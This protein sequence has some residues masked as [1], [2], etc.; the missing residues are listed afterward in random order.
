[1]KDKNWW[2]CVLG[3]IPVNNKGLIAHGYTFQE[4]ASQ[5][6]IENNRSQQ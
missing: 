5:T 2:A 3:K 4:P 1:M 6:T